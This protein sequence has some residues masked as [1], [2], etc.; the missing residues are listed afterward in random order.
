[1]GRIAKRF[2]IMDV[3]TARKV[4]GRPIPRIGG[5]AIF[6]SFVLP[7]MGA[8]FVYTGLLKEV[9]VNPAVMWLGAGGLIVF[10]LGLWDDIRR[11]PALVKF[12]VQVAAAIVAYAGGLR[13]DG[14]FLPGGYVVTFQ[15][16]PLIITVFWFVLVV[17]A[18]NL[19]DGLDG[20]AAGVVFFSA[21]V[22]LVLAVLGGRFVVAM[23]FAALAGSTLGFLRYNFN[24]ASIFMGDGGSYFLGYM[25]AGLSIMGSMKGQTTVALLIPIVAMGEPLIDAIIAP[26][27]RFVRGRPMFQPD[28]GHLHHRLMSLGVNHR[29]TVLIMYGATVVLGVAALGTVFIKD[30][31]AFL[32]L[33]VLAVGIFLAFRKMGYLEYLAVDKIGGYLYDMGDLMGVTS[34]RRTFLDRQIEIAGAPDYDALWQHTTS[35]MELLKIDRAEMRINGCLW[36]MEKGGT[37]PDSFVPSCGAEKTEQIPSCGSEKPGQIPAG[38]PE[39]PVQL[40]IFRKEKI[41]SRPGF[42]SGG[43]PAFPQGVA[44]VFPSV[45]E[46]NGN[47]DGRLTI[48]LP[49]VNGTKNYGTLYL[50][51]DVVRDPLKPFTLRRSLVAALK[52]LDEKTVTAAGK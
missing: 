21:L 9:L 3:P 49:L 35:A 20:L 15:Y 18:T 24:P 43:G 12:G 38:G 27:R 1:V 42:S 44:P 10:L 22:L 19:I 17:N 45:F 33:A 36:S 37:A 6:F 4:H 2:G 26:I 41:G 52:R 51:K 5:V 47:S 31:Y 32:V 48:H 8:F 11:L 14:I 29:N 50:E 40:P 34:D 25:L 23:G 46:E 39:K 16:F 30:F 28:K 13:I 7:F